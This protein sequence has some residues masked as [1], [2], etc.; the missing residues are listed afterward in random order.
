M[1]KFKI[2][3]PILIILLIIEILL[4][5]IFKKRNSNISYYSM[6][7]LFC[8]SGGW[9]NDLINFFLKKKLSSKKINSNLEYDHNGYILKKKN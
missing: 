6:I 2:F 4:C 1:T 7:N 9:S 5:K 8:I 3:S